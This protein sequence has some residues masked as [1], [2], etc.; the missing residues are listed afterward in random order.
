[1]RQARKMGMEPRASAVEQTRRLMEATFQGLFIHDSGVVL[2]ANRAAASI[3]GRP[4]RELSRCRI[5]E[6]LEERSCQLLM[7]KIG[8][9]SNE[10]C[11]I[12]GR[13]KDGS[14][15]PLE[16]TIKAVLTCGGR[17]LEIL[18]VSE[19]TSRFFSSTIRN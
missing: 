19:S 2:D 16:I 15:V 14:N 5:S 18:A 3:F 4:A 9:R 11:S 13:R 7:K 12:T 6:L 1:M 10:P 17:Q 8:S